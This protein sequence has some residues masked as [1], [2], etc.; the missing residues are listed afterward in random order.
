MSWPWSRRRWTQ[1][2]SFALGAGVVRA[3]RA[4]GVGPV[5]RGEAWR[6]RRARNRA[7]RWRIATASYRMSP[8]GPSR[9]SPPRPWC[10]RSADLRPRVAGAPAVIA[11]RDLAVRARQIAPTE[12][13]KRLPDGAG[14]IDERVGRSCARRAAERPRR[15]LDD[16]PLAL[17]RGGG[18]PAARSS[19]RARSLTAT[20]RCVPAARSRSSTWPLSQLVAHDHREVGAVPARGLELPPELAAREVGADRAAPPRAARSRS[21]AA[22]PCPRDRRRRPRPGGPSRPGPLPRPAPRARARSGRAPAR[23]RCPASACRRGAR[24]GRRSGRRR[25]APAAGPRGPRRRTRTP[26]G[27][28]SRGRGRAPGSTRYG[29]PSASRCAWTAAKWSAQAAHRWSVIR[30]APALSATI[31][32][33]LESS[34]RSG[35]RSRRSSS[36]GGRTV[37]V[38][39][40]V[41]L[42]RPRCRRAGR[43]GRRSS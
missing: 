8:A 15:D 31:A 13:R 10:A 33:S 6:D 9:A 2:A 22:R 19:S 42:Q 27:C 7:L 40:V 1:P 36:A 43:P 41:G 5:G 38:A 17:S 4:A 24:P 28:S 25:R 11:R 20:S 21:G 23:T 35:L 37:R 34:S 30:G 39:A 3:Q 26:C 32:G 29:T 18:R 14:R 16:G 12:S